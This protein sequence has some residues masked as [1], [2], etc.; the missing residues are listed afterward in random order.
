LPDAV[1][2]MRDH[3]IA[4][5]AEFADAMDERLQR[6]L[7]DLQRLQ[8]K[9]LQQLELRLEKLVEGV[10]ESRRAQRSQQIHRVFDEYRQWVEDTLTTEPEPYIRVLAAVH[11]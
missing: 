11:H 1:N 4:C 2:A 10:R 5:Q 7:A 6:T 3:M 8:G 9:Q